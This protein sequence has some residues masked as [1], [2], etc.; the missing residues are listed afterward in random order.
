MVQLGNPYNA[1]ESAVSEAAGATQPV[2][3]FSVSGRIGRVR[4]IAYGIGFYFLIGIL[5]GIV[6]LVANENVAI[7]LMFLALL[8]MSFMLTIQ[9]CHDFDTSGWL[10]LVVLVPLANFVFW[11]I[12]GTD[13]PNR[14]GNPTPPNRPGVIVLVCVVPAL[15]FVFAVLAA[16]AIPAYQDYTHRARVAEVIAQ[17]TPWRSAII[18]HHAKTGKLPASAR[19]LPKDGLRESDGRWGKVALSRNGV[20]TLT[21]SGKAGPL[22]A[23]TILLQPKIA[24]GALNWDCTGGTLEVRYRPGSCRAR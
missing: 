14:Y 3:I 19:D 18:E 13:G 10:S 16:V 11:F 9:R 2:K 21:F 23:K 20:L 5:G 6:G 12:P 4:Y 24:E 8:V 7:V 22:A 15:V 17:A 1:P